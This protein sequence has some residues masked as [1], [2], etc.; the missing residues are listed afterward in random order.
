[1]RQ[2]STAGRPEAMARCSAPATSP[3]PRDDLAVAT[4]A[5][6]DGRVVGVFQRGAHLEVEAQLLAHAD[7]APGGVVVDDG[8]HRQAVA[9][10]GIELVQGE[11]E[12]A[13][14][15]D[16]D[17]RPARDAATCSA[18]AAGRPKPRWLMP[19]SWKRVRTSR[20]GVR[21]LLQKVVWPPSYTASASSGIASA[22]RLGERRRMHR[23]LGVGGHHRELAPRARRAPR[24][25]RRARR[26]R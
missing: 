18:I 4:E 16:V 11:A 24:A 22:D 14:A 13:V 7:H 3:A 2:S 5:A 26:A 17:D 1:M 12:G 8:D 25:L 15:G 10:R 20:T 6:R 21:S 19:G 9:A 23:L